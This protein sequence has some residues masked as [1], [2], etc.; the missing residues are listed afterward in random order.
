MPEDRRRDRYQRP[1]DGEFRGNDDSTRYQPTARDGD[2]RAWSNIG[3]QPTEY[4]GH[5]DAPE[6]RY[7]GGTSYQPAVGYGDRAD[8]PM[9]ETERR[10]A[11]GQYWEPLS[12]DEREPEPGYE[13]TRYDPGYR[14]DYRRDDRRR[15][16][17]DHDDDD[18][19]S[20]RGG[21]TV[22][23]VGIVAIVVV[24]ALLL[25]WFATSRDGGGSDTP[26]ATTTE[27]PPSPTSTTPSES[28][29][30]VPSDVQQSIDDLRNQLDSLR[31]NPPAVPG[32]PGVGDGTPPTIPDSAVGASAAGLEVQLRA[33]GLNDL[34]FVRSD[35]TTATNSL[36]TPTAR[37]VAI[38]PAP[39]MEVA[40]G[41][42][43]TITLG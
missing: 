17:D 21:M 9:S 18:G 15:D 11:G 13:D 25:L 5:D 27:A 2:G 36:E 10:A 40:S 19:G 37:V 16:Y 33:M 3:D 34:T 1:R 14:D 29:P 31:Q 7:D 12:E 42:P 22:A 30:S 41:Q 43:V 32:L 20:A 26:T 28:R 39:G 38:D 24:L 35:G 6:T 4:I 23:V 8:R